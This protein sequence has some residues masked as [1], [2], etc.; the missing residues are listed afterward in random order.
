MFFLHIL[1]CTRKLRSTNYS[2]VKICFTGSKG[3]FSG[4]MCETGEKRGCRAPRPCP[5]PLQ[6]FGTRSPAG[7]RAF[8]HRQLNVGSET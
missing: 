4:A 2:K 3:N 7:H 6:H 8:C 1:A 5:I